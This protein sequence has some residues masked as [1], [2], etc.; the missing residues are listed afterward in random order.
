MV[1]GGCLKGIVRFAD[2]NV[3]QETARRATP[4]A[5]EMARHLWMVFSSARCEE[6]EAQRAHQTICWSTTQDTSD[7][8]C[9]TRHLE[10]DLYRHKTMPEARAVSGIVQR[11]RSK[12]LSWAC[13]RPDWSMTYNQPWSYKVCMAACLSQQPD[14]MHQ[15]QAPSSLLAILHCCFLPLLHRC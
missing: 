10:G 3:L 8:S 6:R 11:D 9:P 13:H 4:K 5:A 14:F 7:S 2:A 12:Q 15:T 1:P